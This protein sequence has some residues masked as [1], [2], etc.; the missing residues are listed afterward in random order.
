[1]ISSAAIASKE[2]ANLYGMKVLAHNIETSKQNYTSFVALN[3]SSMQ[4]SDCD[5]AS[6][7]IK[8]NHEPAALY[9]AL[10]V[11]AQRNLNL[12]KL[13]SRPIIGRAWHYLFYVDV[14]V[15]GNDKV[16]I[17]CVN[18]LKNLGREVQLLGSYA[19]GNK[20]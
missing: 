2:S 7:I 13:Q 10:S 12:T 15:G 14:E 18:D 1:M 6:I 20:T 9:N 8:T 16:F 4:V 17:D 3:Q 5:K 19:S 11:F